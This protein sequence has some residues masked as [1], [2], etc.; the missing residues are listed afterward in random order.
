MQRQD[1]SLIENWDIELPVA[2]RSGDA[3]L[4]HDILTFSGGRATTTLKTGTRTGTA[5]VYLRDTG[6]GKI[7]GESFTILPGAPTSITLTSPEVIHAKAGAQGLVTAHIYDRYGNLTTLHDHV[8]VIT[9][10]KPALLEPLGQPREVHTGVYETRITSRGAPGRVLFRGWL[11]KSGKK[12]TIATLENVSMTN[13]LPVITS[14]EAASNAWQNITQ[15]L[16]GGAFGQ[17]P[18]Q[19]YF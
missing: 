3:K 1:G 11:E 6:L 5:S 17:T 18:V 14:E 9:A 10:D 15:V 2:I 13:A 7:V 4:S 16:L 8:L 19:G 12:S